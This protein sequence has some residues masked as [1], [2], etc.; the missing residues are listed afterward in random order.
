VP[1]ET[2]YHALVDHAALRE[3]FDPPIDGALAARVKRLFSHQSL[4]R[5]RALGPALALDLVR[6]LRRR[7]GAADAIAE[8]VEMFVLPQLDGLVDE[9]ARR[10][11]QAVVAAV[12]DVLSDEARAQL[13][14]RV[15]E[16]GGGVV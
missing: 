4:L 16:L 6:Y 2:T 9:S 10:V 1:D 7:G 15:R 13:V 8:G 14:A 11:E 3:G 5:E 12:G